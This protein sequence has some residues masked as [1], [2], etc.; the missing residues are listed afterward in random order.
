MTE[1]VP[2]INDAHIV[3]AYE[4]IWAIG[5][6][7]IPNQEEIEEVHDVI[8]KELNSISYLKVIYGGSVNEKNCDEIFSILNVDGALIGGSSLNFKE[9]LAI[10]NSGVKYLD[11]FKR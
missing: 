10:Y 8:K 3:V 1:S 9:F 2:L 4:P 11:S 6:G 5:S 7:K